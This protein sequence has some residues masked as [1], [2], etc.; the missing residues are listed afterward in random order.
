VRR[1]RAGRL[2]RLLDLAQIAAQRYAEVVGRN[3]P[4]AAADAALLARAV[5]RGPLPGLEVDPHRA[6]AAARVAQVDRVDAVRGDPV[7]RA[8]EVARRPAGLPRELDLAARAVGL[9]HAQVLAREPRRGVEAAHEREAAAGPA[10][11]ALVVDVLGVERR[12]GRLP[13]GSRGRCRT[14]HAAR[15]AR[16][17]QA[18]DAALGEE[19]RR[20]RAAARRGLPGASCG[21]VTQGAGARAGPRPRAR[22]AA[23]RSTTAAAPAL[24]LRDRGQL[25]VRRERE[26]EHRSLAVL[27]EA[28]RGACGEDLLEAALVLLSEIRA[29]VVEARATRRGRR[30]PRP[31]RATGRHDSRRSAVSSAGVSAISTGAPATAARGR[32]HR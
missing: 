26:V 2:E 10:A 11:R 25:S 13:G 17:A 1:I 21:L 29:S 16:R 32:A 19:R 4:L 20:P 30:R 23:A 6:A 22:A 31:A 7:M 8:A 27:A 14:R 24:A 12:P 28:E 5:E 15:A 3:A 9:G 18:L